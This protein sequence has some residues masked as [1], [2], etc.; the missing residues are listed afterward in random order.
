MQVSLFGLLV[1]C[2]PDTLKNKTIPMNMD[3]GLKVKR[4]NSRRKNKGI[5]REIKS[6]AKSYTSNH[7]HEKK[8]MRGH[9]A[10]RRQL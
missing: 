9:H 2:T 7:R 6:T 4:Q 1:T 5:Q 3:E 8:E 10:Y